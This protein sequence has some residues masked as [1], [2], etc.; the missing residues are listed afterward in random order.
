[1]RH[2][3]LFSV[4]VCIFVLGYGAIGF[5]FLPMAGFQGDLTRI[6]MLPEAQFGWRKPQP[7]IDPK[8]IRQSS[9]QEAEVLVIG[10]SFSDNP[11]APSRIWQT[12]LTQNGLK[13]RTEHWGNIRGICADFMPWLRAQGFRGQFVILQIVERHISQGLEEYMNCQHMQPHPSVMADMPR[14]PPAISFDPDRNDYSGR[15]S[16]GLQTALNYR[17][18]ADF[19]NAP[20]FKSVALTNGVNIARVK[21]GCD[22]F[23]HT[24]CNDALFLAED[25][26][27]EVDIHALENIDKL[28][29]RMQGITPIWVFVPNKLTAYLY[30]EKHF[31][32]EAERRFHA[33][34]LL[35][36][37]QQALKE[38]TVDLYPANNT[39]FST[40]GYLLMGEEIFRAMQ[41]APPKETR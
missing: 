36:M 5:Y 31:W 16:A 13:V 32:N 24:R 39:H 35:R 20:D 33:P 41:Q 18:Y 28:N 34:N 15:F 11:P 38:K 17:H 2:A 40:T 1:M 23:S 29:G 26:A 3:K 9:L 37:T 19:S 8:L 6:G 14:S 27:E 12:V 10:D 25:S 22:L 30:P 4:L 7:P 21:D